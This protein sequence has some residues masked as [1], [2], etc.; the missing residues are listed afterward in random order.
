MNKSIDECILPLQLE[1][2]KDI[3]CC[4]CGHSYTITE[5]ELK[6]FTYE[7]FGPNPFTCIEIVAF[8]PFKN[9]DRVRGFAHLMQKNDAKWEF[10][11]SINEQIIKKIL[12]KI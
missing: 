11:E 9:C 8:C 5:N 3:V 6:K 1:W 10:D 2:K 12:N 4:K 7:W